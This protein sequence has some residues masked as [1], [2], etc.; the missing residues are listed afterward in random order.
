MQAVPPPYPSPRAVTL[1]T[2]EGVPVLFVASDSTHPTSKSP[3][4]ILPRT[5]P[6]PTESSKSCVLKAKIAAVAETFA[7]NRYVSP[8]V[9][10]PVHSLAEVRLTPVQT[11]VPVPSVREEDSYTLSVS[12]TGTGLFIALAIFGTKNNAEVKIAKI[13]YVKKTNL[14]KIFLLLVF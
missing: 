12:I 7:S 2:I 3:T 6:V 10:V 11:A 8:S 9:R 13:K 1:L 4:N 14:I 5:S